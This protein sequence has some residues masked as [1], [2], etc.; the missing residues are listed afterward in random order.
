MKKTRTDAFLEYMLTCSEEQRVL[1]DDFFRTLSRQLDLGLEQN[2]RI[3]KDFE[4]AVLYYAENGVSL[5]EAFSRLDPARLG[6]FYARDAAVWYPLDSAAKVYPLSMGHGKMA[7]FRLSVYLK[8]EVVPQL[9][10]LALTFTMGR[11]PSFAT[12]L[13]KGFF[14]HYLDGWKGRYGV[15]PD[16]VPPCR[17]MKVGR[18]GV[19]PLKVLWRKNR[20]SVEFFHILTDGTGGMVFLKTLTA[21]YLRLLGEDCPKEDGVL[22]VTAL[23]DDEETANEFPRVLREKV[24]G[25]FADRGA[26]QLG[27]KTSR[28]NPCQVLRLKLSAQALSRAAKTRGAT[29]TAYLLSRMMVACRAAMENTRGDISVQVPVNMRKF[30]P[31]RTLRNFALYCGVRF[32]AGEIRDADALLPGI[33]AQ[34]EKKASRAAL[35]KMV[36]STEKLVAAAR[37]LPLPVKF[38]VVQAVYGVLGDRIFTTTLSNLGVV[39][40]P[41]ELAQRVESMDFVLGTARINRALCSLV[42]FGDVASFCIAKQTKDPTFEETFL[43]LLQQD[44]LTVCIEGSDVYDV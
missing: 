40:V 37:Y 25:G 16:D 20:I 6:G 23:P 15:L 17:A 42:T 19:T 24:S 36:A 9:L 1:A 7:V 38:P 35:D 8:T 2:Q 4:D 14:W 11:F 44:G 12:T 26:L 28:V 33:M 27:G 10:Q 31:S 32:G 43:R 41:E 30:Y 3:K 22:D 21:E 34:L 5:S 18:T 29:V 13:K 39:Q